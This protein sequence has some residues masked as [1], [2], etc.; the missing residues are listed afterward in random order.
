LRCPKCGF[1][2]TELESVDW[3]M[4]GIT[5]KDRMYGNI[6]TTEKPHLWEWIKTDTD[7]EKMIMEWERAKAYLKIV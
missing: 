3:G 7:I 2:D 5:P 4:D 1:D 6:D